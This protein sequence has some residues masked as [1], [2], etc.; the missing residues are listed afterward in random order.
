MPVWERDRTIEAAMPC[1]GGTVE[2]KANPEWTALEMICSGPLLLSIADIEHLEDGFQQFVRECRARILRK[3]VAPI[4]MRGF[5]RRWN[6][7]G[8]SRLGGW[9]VAQEQVIAGS[10]GHLSADIIAHKV[11]QQR[12]TEA[13]ERGRDTVHKV[14]ARGVF[15]RAVAM[16]ILLAEDGRQ[17]IGHVDGGGSN[18]PTYERTEES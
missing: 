8:D 2:L 13:H 9:S 10:W 17:Y 11:M 16:G 5:D 3:P 7:M 4:D 12:H 14:G 15:I 18:W 6:A 1:G